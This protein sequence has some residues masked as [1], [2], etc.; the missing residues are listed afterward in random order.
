M[1]RFRFAAL[2]FNLIIGSV[3]R[4]VGESFSRRDNSKFP[5]IC[6]KCSKAVSELSE[7]GSLLLAPRLLQISQFN[8]I[9]KFTGSFRSKFPDKL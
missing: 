3:S 9:G 6:A 5:E 7:D 2:E 4:C 1:V 8:A